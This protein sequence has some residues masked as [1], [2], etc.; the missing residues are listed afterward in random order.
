ALHRQAGGLFARGKVFPYKI[1]RDLRAALHSAC[2]GAGVPYAPPGDLRR[3]SLRDH[4]HSTQ[5]AGFS[6][7]AGNT[8]LERATRLAR[9]VAASLEQK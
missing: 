9:G 1:E 8:N 6:A 4:V 7:Q 3:A 2:R 5:S